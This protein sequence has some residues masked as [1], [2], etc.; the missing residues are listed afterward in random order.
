MGFYGPKIAIIES[1]ITILLYVYSVL[2]IS[3]EQMMMENGSSDKSLD[4]WEVSFDML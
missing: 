1:N 2:L 4:P 3:F